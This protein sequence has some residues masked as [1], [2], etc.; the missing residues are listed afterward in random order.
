MAAF[1]LLQDI[2]DDIDKIGSMLR[3]SIKKLD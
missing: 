3:N 1:E 2:L